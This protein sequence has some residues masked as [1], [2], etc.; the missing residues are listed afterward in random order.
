MIRDH[1][2]LCIQARNMADAQYDSIEET[3]LFVKGFTFVDILKYTELLDK[4][5]KIDNHYNTAIINGRRLFSDRFVTD[6]RHRILHD[7]DNGECGFAVRATVKAEMR[8]L[9]S[10]KVTALILN[11][12]TV[13]SPKLFCSAKF[14]L[15]QIDRGL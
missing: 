1:V 13:S 2:T 4:T 9:T 8:K 12:N 14:N 11:D 6:I 3:P 15:S 10:Y 7:K 5:H